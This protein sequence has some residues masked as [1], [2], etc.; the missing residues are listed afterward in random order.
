[1]AIGRINIWANR[2]KDFFWPSDGPRGRRCCIWRIAPL[3]SATPLRLLLR[4]SAVIRRHSCPEPVRRQ[5]EPSGKVVCLDRDSVTVDPDDRRGWVHRGARRNW[6]SKVG[7]SAFVFPVAIARRLRPFHT[8]D[9]LGDRLLNCRSDR[10]RF[11]RWLGLLG[12]ED[13]FHIAGESPDNW[14]GYP[15]GLSASRCKASVWSM[16]EIHP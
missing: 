3:P 15:A 4:S 12:H 16:I 1:M 9:L 14:L 13:L 8:A 2:A 11:R 7:T 6:N 10:L 5:A